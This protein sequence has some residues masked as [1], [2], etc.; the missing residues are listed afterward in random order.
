M[1]SYSVATSSQIV[2]ADSAEGAVRSVVW[3]I[4]KSA[5]CVAYF[6]LPKSRVSI[7]A[8]GAIAI[9]LGIQEIEA[10]DASQTSV[11]VSVPAARAG[12]IASYTFNSS[13]TYAGQSE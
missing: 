1:G 10:L 9:A 6:A 13:K 2:L 12:V 8:V 7:I 3:T 11:I 4:A 5:V